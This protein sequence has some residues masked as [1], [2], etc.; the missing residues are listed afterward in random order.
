MARQL[1]LRNLGGIIVVDFLSMSRR[2]DGERLLAALN[3]AVRDD[4]VQTEVYGLSRLGLVELTRARRG[5][6][7]AELMT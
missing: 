7:L 4:P 3:A 6:A 2:A 5:P 1:R